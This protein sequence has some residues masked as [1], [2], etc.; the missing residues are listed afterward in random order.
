MCSEKSSMSQREKKSKTT[1]GCV[2]LCEQNGAIVTILHDGFGIAKTVRT[3]EIWTQILDDQ[4]VSKAA[5]FMDDIVSK[6]A[7]FDWDLNVKT[8]NS[9]IS[10]PFAGIRLQNNVLIVAAKT[11][12]GLNKLLDEFIRIGNEQSNLIRSTLKENVDLKARFD[13]DSSSYDAISSL[14]NELVTLQRKLTKSNMQ[15][16]SLNNL[17]NQFLGIAAHDLR[18]PLGNLLN[19]SEFLIDD[20]E[21]LSEEHIDVVRTIRQLSEEM[22][23]LVNEL[24]DYAAI[25]SGQIDLLLEPGDIIA[26]MRKNVDLNTHLAARKHIEIDF[27]PDASSLF[28]PVDTGKIKQVINNLISNAIKY[29]NAGSR[30]TIRIDEKDSEVV[31]AV[32]DQGLGIPADELKLLFKPFQKTSTKSTADEKSTGLGLFIVKRIVESHGGRIWAESEVGKGSVFS[33]ALPKA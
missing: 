11:T 14:N 3:G 20:Q 29:S 17:K 33:F 7:T 21:S 22:L 26:L 28:I 12:N 18:N 19:L 5:L 6:G 1:K 15:L 8:E 30:I 2:L 32:H 9:V 24:L 10:V 27:Q 23:T 16:E 13:R 31:V 25:E 4:C